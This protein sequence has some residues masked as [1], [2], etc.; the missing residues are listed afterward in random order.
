MP[1]NTLN[2]IHTIAEKYDVANHTTGI[3]RYPRSKQ[4]VFNTT[5]QAKAKQQ[6]VPT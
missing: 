6:S 3:Y 1:E 4:I 2:T 5:V